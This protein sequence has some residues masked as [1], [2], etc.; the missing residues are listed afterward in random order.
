MIHKSN[1]KVGRWLVY[2]QNIRYSSLKTKEHLHSSGT[3][4]LQSGSNGFVELLYS[5]GHHSELFFNRR[6]LVCRYHDL[7]QTKRTE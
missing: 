3:S 2:I 4:N 1:Q 6:V 5:I 7:L